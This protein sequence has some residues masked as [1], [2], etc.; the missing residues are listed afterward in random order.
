MAGAGDPEDLDQ[1]IAR[2]DP[3][4]W[5]ASRFIGDAAARADVIALYAYDHELGRARRAATTP[6]MAEIRLTWWRE[7][8]DE[9][10]EN[11]PVR[12]HPTAQ[13]LAGAV[14]RRAL[15]R[16][17]L[18]AMI[19]G[20]IDIA[21]ASALTT[22]QA[23]AFA[24]AVEGSAA[25]LAVAIL[26]QT[27]PTEAAGAAGRAWGLALLRRAGLAAPET[28]DNALRETLAAARPDALRLSVAA[29]PAA[30]SAALVRFDLAGRGVGPLRKR[31][32]LIVA[33]VTGRL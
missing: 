9:M 1:L 28:V 33:S 13:A 21:D 23:L 5:L 3:D 11:R 24:D 18:E 2:V 19:D 8:L 17:P 32:Q 25:R 16:E 12:R 6:L 14:R 26:D 29:F 10:F 31:L 20:W 4:R 27:A 7:A 30:L 15:P 22:E